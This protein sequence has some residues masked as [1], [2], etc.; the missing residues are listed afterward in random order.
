MEHAL[1]EHALI[2]AFAIG[3]CAIRACKSGAWSI[4][5]FAV[6]A[7][8]SGACSNNIYIYVPS[9]IVFSCL[10]NVCLLVE[11]G[12]FCI[13]SYYGTKST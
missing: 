1:L 5:A 13:D 11:Y 10:V 8:A 9:F 4:G 7:C 3:A 12:Y 6:G 2:G